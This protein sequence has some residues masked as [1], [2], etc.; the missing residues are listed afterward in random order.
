MHL[1]K[2]LFKSKKANLISKLILLQLKYYVF[3][4][5]CKK[6]NACFIYNSCLTLNLNMN[7]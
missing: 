7:I 3:L 2:Q 5:D 6:K 4:I 1:K